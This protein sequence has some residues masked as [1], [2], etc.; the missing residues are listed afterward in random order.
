[1]NIRETI[2]LIED[3]RFSLMQWYVAHRG[4]DGLDDLDKPGMNML[5]E[6]LQNDGHEAKLIQRNLDMAELIIDGTSV[7]LEYWDDADWTVDINIHQRIQKFL[8]SV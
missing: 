5:L 1:M 2:G 7:F 3:T 6:Q 4:I 8:K